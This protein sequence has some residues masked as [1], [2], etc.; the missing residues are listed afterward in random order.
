MRIDHA[1]EIYRKM[2][3]EKGVVI[4]YQGSKINCKDCVRITVGTPEQNDVLLDTLKETI[5]EIGKLYEN[6]SA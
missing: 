6:G 2:A 5:V 3:S 4:R 1:Q